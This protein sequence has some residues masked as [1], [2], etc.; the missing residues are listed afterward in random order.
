MPV[1]GELMYTL[2]TGRVHHAQDL[3]PYSAVCSQICL[4]C[5]ES[6]TQVTNFPVGFVFQPPSSLRFLPY[7][8][9]FHDELAVSAYKACASHEKGE[10]YQAF[11]IFLLSK[12]STFLCR[13]RLQP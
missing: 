7:H 4:S 9:C 12:L 11:A 1:M 3:T 5:L 13:R 6:S 10:R 2:H 8:T